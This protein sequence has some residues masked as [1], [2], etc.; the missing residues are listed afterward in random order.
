MIM[1]EPE[2]PLTV[3]DALESRQQLQRFPPGKL[4]FREGDE[5][6][7]VYIIHAGE[8]DL[9]L[10]SKNGQVKPFIVAEP[11]SIL[12]LSCVVS[13]NPHDCTALARNHCDIGFVE[14]ADFLQL[15]DESPAVWFTVL[16]HMSQ[17]LN[18]CYDSMRHAVHTAR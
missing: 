5:A 6:R 1:T 8:V 11:G 14:A 17:D 15:L 3:V 12:G 4:L 10:Q 7:G 16:R 18:S 9:L 2:R 13:R